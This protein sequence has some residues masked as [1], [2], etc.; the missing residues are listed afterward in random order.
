VRATPHDALWPGVP[1]AA[2]AAWDARRASVL[3]EARISAAHMRLAS[4]RVEDDATAATE[5]GIG[6]HCAILEPALFEQRY[7]RGLNRPRRGGVNVAAHAAF[8]LEQLTA[9]REVL[10][11]REYEKCLR[12]RDA[13]ARQEWRGALL[14]GPGLVEL[15]LLWTDDDS[16]VRCKARID[17]VTLSYQRSGWP[18]PAPVVVD[19]KTA[20]DA[21][22]EGFRRAISRYSYHV[23]A[24]LQLEGLA[25]HDPKTWLDPGTLEV[26]PE[27]YVWLVL[28]KA[29]PWEAAL[30]SPSTE[31]LEEGGLRLRH[32][33]AVWADCERTG[34]WPGF[35][36]EPLLLDLPAWERRAEQR[37]RERW[38]GAPRLRHEERHTLDRRTPDDIF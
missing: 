12:I 37:E 34:R 22:P 5:L 4:V 36:P 6:V 33:L 35:S 11:D 28:E 31:M 15:S 14:D 19:V 29:E 16:A 30:Y 24:R 18:S 32:A 3:K 38:T 9:G 2:Y 8:D 1:Y 7:V 27:Q 17:R 20:E 25:A 13:L 21:T 26:R 10:S 23:Q